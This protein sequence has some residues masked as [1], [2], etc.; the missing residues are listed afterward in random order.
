MHECPVWFLVPGRQTTVFWVRLYELY[1]GKENAWGWHVP[2][3]GLCKSSPR[4]SSAYLNI[5]LEVDL[6]GNTISVR[7]G[8]F[9]DCR[10]R[11]GTNCRTVHFHLNSWESACIALRLCNDLFLEAILEPIHT[12]FLINI[13]VLIQ[14][15]F[16]WHS[17]HGILSLVVGRRQ[18]FPDPPCKCPTQMCPGGFRNHMGGGGGEVSKKHLL[19]STNGCVL[20]VQNINRRSLL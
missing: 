17:V 20:W 15:S 6:M 11:E 9:L 10:R 12:F 1:Q 5:S 8:R 13:L 16:E 14:R 18:F 7:V 2:T 19:P 3:V 4:A